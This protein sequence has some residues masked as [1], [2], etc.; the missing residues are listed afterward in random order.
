MDLGTEH[1]LYE[2]AGGVATITLNRPEAL[3]ACTGEMYRAVKRA[4]VL[5]DNDPAVSVVV[6]TGAGR[7][8]CPGG[9]LKAGAETTAAPGSRKDAASRLQLGLDVLP[10]KTIETIGTTV[11]CAVNGLAQGG[12]LIMVLASDVVIA[13]DRATFRV[14]ELERGIADGWLPMRL[15]QRVGLARAKYLIFTGEEID[16]HE[17]ERIGLVARVVPHDEL[18]KATHEACRR[19]M[20]ASPAARKATKAMLNRSLPE[21]DLRSFVDSL[22]GSEAAE[23]MRAFAEG[24][25]PSWVPPEER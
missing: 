11:V 4:L 14:A 20:Q 8:F 23:G 2:V 19:I 17:A 6:L 12:G 10:F 18:E 22:L 15:P 13:S 16:A 21:E 5:A 1:V 25:K 24:R 7:A 9:D 3:N